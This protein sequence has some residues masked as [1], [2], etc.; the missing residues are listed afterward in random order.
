[1]DLQVT[2]DV[3]QRISSFGG[4]YKFVETAQ[5]KYF[6]QRKNGGLKSLGR[7]SLKCKDDVPARISYNELTKDQDKAIRKEFKIKKGKKIETTSGIRAIVMWYLTDQEV[8]RARF[9]R[10][11]PVPHELILKEAQ[12][13]VSVLKAQAELLA[14]E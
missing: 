6:R 3:K 10:S 8:Q 11:A 9:K 5:R 1:M 14:G 12:H 4:S 2:S 7:R 13:E